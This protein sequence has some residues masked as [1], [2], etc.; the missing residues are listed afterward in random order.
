VAQKLG[1]P[2]ACGGR[3]QE[4]ARALPLAQMPAEPVPRLADG[5][6]TGHARRHA[7]RLRHFAPAT[8]RAIVQKEPAAPFPLVPEP[9][10]HGE[11]P[12]LN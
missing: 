10:R 4:A 3:A 7:S 1:V 11:I 6:P 5:F 8:M 2:A 12:L 9:V